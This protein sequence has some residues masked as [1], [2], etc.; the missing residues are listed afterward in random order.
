[1]VLTTCQCE[2]FKKIQ[3]GTGYYCCDFFTGKD[4]SIEPLV[5]MTGDTGEVALNV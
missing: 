5:C 2:L 1:M 4:R 3:N